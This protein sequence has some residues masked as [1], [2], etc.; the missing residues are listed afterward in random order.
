MTK[1]FYLAG[2]AALPDRA[3]LIILAVAAAILLFTGSFSRVMAQESV[4]VDFGSGE[5]GDVSMEGFILPS[6]A[7]VTIDVVCLDAH[8]T[9]PL[10]TDAW[11]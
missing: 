6:D 9:Q 10:A 5:F 4:L 8:R 2:R 7:R 3:R 11:I 1:N